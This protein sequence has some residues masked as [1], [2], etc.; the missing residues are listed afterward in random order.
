M[1]RTTIHTRTDKANRE[2]LTPWEYERQHRADKKAAKSW[3]TD[4]QG[5]R[6]L[7]SSDAFKAH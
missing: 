2:A 7:A 3:R 6:A 4:R 5:R 1:A